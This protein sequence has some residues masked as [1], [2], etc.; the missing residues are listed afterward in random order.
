MQQTEIFVPKSLAMELRKKGFNEVC[1]GWYSSNMH[2][3]DSTKPHLEGE[4]VLNE[5]FDNPN[6]C[7][8]PTYDQV[9][10]WF[11]S[12]GIEIETTACEDKTY[13]ADIVTC[14]NWCV[15]FESNWVENRQQSLLTAFEDALNLI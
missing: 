9:V 13:S 12:K 14:Y 6:S 1:I 8:A 15:V 7:T 11:A 4:F 10:G 3:H 2:N 5:S